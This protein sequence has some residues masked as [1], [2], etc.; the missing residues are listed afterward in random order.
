LL[1]HTILPENR[2]PFERRSQRIVIFGLADSTEIS[3]ESLWPSGSALRGIV[4]GG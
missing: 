3:L 1:S 4:G 2:L